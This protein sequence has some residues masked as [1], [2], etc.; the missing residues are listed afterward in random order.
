M[1]VKRLLRE[2]D[3]AEIAEWMAFDR[4]EPIGSGRSNLLA[5][6]SFAYQANVNRDRTK[7]PEPYDADDFVPFFDVY[8]PP[9]PAKNVDALVIEFFKNRS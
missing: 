4:L 3:S 2:I 8:T 5:A 1:T 7:R 6:R 9:A